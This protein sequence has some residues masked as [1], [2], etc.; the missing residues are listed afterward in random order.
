MISESF[1]SKHRTYSLTR[2]KI[3]KRKT[4]E[5]EDI[6]KRKKR[7]K[8]LLRFL[9]RHAVSYHVERGVDTLDVVEEL[10]AQAEAVRRAFHEA[11]NVCL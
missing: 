9:H 5:I 10:V 3:D 4:A 11:R 1:V 7:R 8:H 6:E 2:Q